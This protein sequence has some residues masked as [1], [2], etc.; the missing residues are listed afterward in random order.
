VRVKGLVRLRE[1]LEKKKGEGTKGCVGGE[2]DEVNSR[3]V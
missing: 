1:I 3:E 2:G